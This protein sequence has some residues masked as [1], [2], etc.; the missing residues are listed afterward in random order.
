MDDPK[1][2][3]PLRDDPTRA[4]QIDVAR[5]AGVSLATVDRVLHRRPGVHARTLARV[6]AAI[7]AL[8]YRPDPAASRLATGRTERLG[9]LLP[10]GNNPFIAMLADQVRAAAPWLADQR[11]LASVTSVDVFAPQQ[12]AEALLECGRSHDAV[13]VMG[14]DHPVV[15]EAIDEIVDQGTVV[16]TLVS[17]VPASRRQRFV[18][19]DNVAAGRTA[20]TLLGRFLCPRSRP[21]PPRDADAPRLP[22]AIVAGSLSLRDHAERCFGFGQVIGTEYPTLQL[23]PPI[24]AF[25]DSERS[26][27][28]TEALLER[29]PGIVGVY[30]AGAGN[31]GIAAALRQRERA[32]RIVYI[33]HELTPFARRFLLDGVIDAVISQDAGHEIRSACR[34]ALALLR[35]E[36]VLTDQE[37]IRI[38]VF[39]KDNLP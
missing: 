20:A 35:D 30:S 37:R 8:D 5:H 25:D 13:I 2:D 7:R 15:R 39:L 11:A 3:D 9:M 23:L 10:A 19:I 38:D 6:E 24:E 4:R 17:D 28:L 32:G 18:G 12:L 27:A 21:A 1:R 33:A 31:R 36:A 16:V 22:V 26:E 14:N 34:I 29:T